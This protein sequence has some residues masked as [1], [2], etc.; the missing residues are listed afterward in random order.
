MGSCLECRCVCIAGSIVHIVG[1]VG[2]FSGWVQPVNWFVSKWVRV[3]CL[4]LFGGVHVGA[5]VAGLLV[6]YHLYW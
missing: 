3:C 1:G 6:S 2:F 5:L 4:G